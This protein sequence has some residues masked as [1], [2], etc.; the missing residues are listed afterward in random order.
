MR[1]LGL[2]FAGTATDRRGE[3]SRFLIETL[4]LQPIT[5][6]GVE[7]DLFGLPDGS[8]FAVASPG[9]MGATARSIGFLVDD[10]DQA[11]AELAGAQV[12]VGPAA[13]NAG[14]RYAHFR[15]PDGQLY[16]LVESKPATP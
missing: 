10:L 14:A 9:G 8:Q 5:V 15:A 12:Q 1:I 3:M 11:R 13:E 6:D 2:T 7:A 16:E 4:H